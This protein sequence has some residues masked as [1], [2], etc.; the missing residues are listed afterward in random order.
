MDRDGSDLWKPARELLT[1][2]TDIGCSAMNT[3]RTL[4]IC[5]KAAVP[6]QQNRPSGAKQP[7]AVT[8]T[9]PSMPLPKQD[10]E[11]SE[12]TLSCYRRKKEAWVALD[13]DS[14]GL[15]SQ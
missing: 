4:S 11:A 12:E 13:R 8:E 15:H 5:T 1:L 9:T 14:S 2:N 7:A 6:K 3:H 10:A